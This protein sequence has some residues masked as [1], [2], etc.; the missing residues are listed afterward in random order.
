MFYR[1]GKI[2]HKQRKEE[3]SSV[4]YS[5]KILT[6]YDIAEI[7]HVSYHKALEFIK[8]SGI[9]YIKIGNQYRVTE[10]KFYAFV[11]AKGRKIV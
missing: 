6:A 11:S 10:E 8:C 1:Y 2:S 3:V 5:L 7:L 9:D 4:N